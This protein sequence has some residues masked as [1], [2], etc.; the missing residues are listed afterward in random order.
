M[1]HTLLH[2]LSTI[3]FSLSQ[4][5]LLIRFKFLTNKAK[6]LAA[7]ELHWDSCSDLIAISTI[8][9]Y[10][11]GHRVHGRAIESTGGLSLV[12]NMLLRGLTISI[13][14]LNRAQFIV[15]VVYQWTSRGYGQ[16]H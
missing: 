16:F 4:I 14:M 9:C 12:L 7:V 2:I 11:E 10:R 6:R 8:A 13:V 5:S 1:L 3:L 15:K